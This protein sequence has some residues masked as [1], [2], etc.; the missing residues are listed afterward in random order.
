MNESLA[1]VVDWFTGNWRLFES[2][3][4]GNA[5]GIRRSRDDSRGWGGFDF[6]P[7]FFWEQP[8]RHS[9]WRGRDDRGF[10]IAEL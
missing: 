1:N 9:V 5:E 2:S 7:R 6:P 8:D 10:R 4:L 3:G